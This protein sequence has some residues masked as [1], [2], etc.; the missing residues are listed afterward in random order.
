MPDEDIKIAKKVTVQI[1]AGKLTAK[2]D[3][4]VN[5]T[6][7][8]SKFKTADKE[9]SG[10]MIK[11]NEEAQLVVSGSAAT[12]QLKIKEKS[13]GFSRGKTIGTLS[14][15]LEELGYRKVAKQYRT[16]DKNGS[17]EL[18]VWISDFDKSEKPETAPRTPKLS[19]SSK[20]P[21][22]PKTPKTPR[23]EKGDKAEKNDKGEPETPGAVAQRKG[24]LGS[25]KGSHMNL[26][27]SPSSPLANTGSMTSLRSPKASPPDSN[28][29]PSDT[30]RLSDKSG[31]SML[32][33]GSKD[34]LKNKND[35]I[36]ASP[37]I[38]SPPL[39]SS[40]LSPPYRSPALPSK[41]SNQSIP[42]F[43][44]N[45][46]PAMRSTSGGVVDSRS[47]S[48]T[49]SGS[50]V[51][52]E[53]VSLGRGIPDRSAN[54]SVP[55]LPVNRRDS[56]S[57]SSSGGGNIFE[58][59]L[60]A[61]RR[62]SQDDVALG[63]LQFNRSQTEV[64]PT[65][66][67]SGGTLPQ[68]R[69]HKKSASLGGATMMRST[70]ADDSGKSKF[71][72]LVKKKP[73]NRD[74]MI[75]DSVIISPE[76]ESSNGDTPS[77]LSLM[78]SAVLDEVEEENGKEVEK[79]PKK[80]GKMYSLRSSLPSIAKMS[81]STK[82]DHVRNKSTTQFSSGNKEE[83]QRNP[84]K[85][86]QISSKGSNLS[87]KGSSG[88]IHESPSPS[89]ADAIA[90]AIDYAENRSSEL[91]SVTP[92]DENRLYH[93]ATSP[94]GSHSHSPARGGMD[95]RQNSDKDSLADLEQVFKKVYEQNKLL[96]E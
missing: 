18:A 50:A 53:A 83:L 5:M 45:S 84:S 11:W 94:L 71:R 70:F 87:S 9:V 43:K 10:N 49:L 1:F 7:G 63:R 64:E 36:L 12:I 77:D 41:S 54:Q 27:A 24:L 23:I 80:R 81:N 31:G 82:S 52:A 17:I 76:N 40:P 85:G 22:S 37:A 39:Q 30:K 28:R 88:I 20:I 6:L 86:S 51:D 13:S 2:R 78:E 33:K 47:E 15:P 62:M 14:I 58:K 89:R 26:T 90:S 8:S 56:P 57:S 42:A 93:S 38:T 48:K 60:K 69:G 91:D 4:H 55:S 59:K 75:R 68:H 34:S 21:G 66:G 74:S 19:K 73:R 32:G 25:W 16:L 61:L 95:A 35:S 72:N 92:L 3:C 65:A 96:K 44:Q 67:T 29:R 79:E 46:M